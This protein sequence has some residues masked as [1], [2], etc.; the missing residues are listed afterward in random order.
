MNL[1]NIDI[2]ICPSSYKKKILNKLSNIDKLYNIKFYNKKEFI[3]NYYFTYNDKTIYYLINKYNLDIDVVKV[4]LNNLYFIDINKKYKSSKLEYLK[5]IKKELLDNNLLIENNIFRNYI[6]NKKINII[7]YYELE[8]YEEKIFNYESTYNIKSNINVYEYNTLEEEV[9]NTC[10][11]IIELINKGIDINKI[12]VSYNS[13]DYNY[14]IKRLFNYYNIPINIKNNNS[15]YGT[16]VVSDYLNNYK[17]DLNNNDNLDIN[18]Q[19]L[20]IE[21]ELID[22]PKDEIYTKLLINKIKSTKQKSIILKNAVNVIDI[23]KDTIEDDEY[24]FLLGFNNDIY[25]TIDKD[26]DYISDSEKEEIDLYPTEYKNSRR[27]K[28]LMNLISN[29]KNIIISYKLNTPFDSYLPSNLID[30]YNFNIIKENTND[31]NYSNIYNKLRLAN[32]LDSYNLYGEKDQ[33][34]DKLYTHYKLDYNSY[35]HKYTGINNDL[36]IS[37]LKQPIKLSYSSLNK[38]NECNF[39]YYLD[40]ILYLNTYEDRFE[41]FIGSL[42]HDVLAKLDNKFDENIYNKYL[43]NRELTNKEKLLLERIKVELI[44]LVKEILN[45]WNYI[46]YKDSLNEEQFNIELERKI[47]VNFEGYID[48][49]LYK[50]DTNF[51]YAIIDY[52]SGDIDTDILSLKYGLKLQLPIYLY[53]I[54]NT[55]DNAIFTGMYYQKI[56]F[57]YP[58]ITYKDNIDKLNKDNYKL[59]G[60]S[61]DNRDVLSI[62]DPNYTSSDLIRSMSYKNDKYGP[63]T[64][65][66]SDENINDLLNYTSNII[67]KCIDDISNAK[68]DINPKIYKNKDISCKYC[69]YK[70]ICYKDSSDY[71][72]LDT[73]EDLSF[74][75]G[76]E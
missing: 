2:I 36:F 7:N 63:H 23:Y 57:D 49:V 47:K 18:K 21:E 70:D 52:K 1:D 10:I 5:N 13:N 73:V 51:K 60:Y 22:I 45:E 26:I 32:L 40:N 11:K 37:N 8:K 48:K 67:N 44:D 39:K 59:I 55:I 31:Y 54:N 53:L 17:L 76:E 25:P 28:V 35:N 64:K 58:N 9:N 6:R 34:L 43:E 27:K 15:I 30:E 74:L 29:I 20:R 61:T 12:F 50:K 56:L 4:Y 38:Y 41:A 72:Y 71:T 24:L 68:F 3:D 75:G 62:F 16:K 33:D 69:N 42:Y 66:L 14:T 65:V 46:G 19:L